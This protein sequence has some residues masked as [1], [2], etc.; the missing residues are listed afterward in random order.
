MEA[1]LKQCD[2][3][4]EMI[5]ASAVKCRYCCEYL[6]HEARR[7]AAGRIPVRLSAYNPGLSAV[8]STIVPGLGQ[9]FQGRILLGI[10]IWL[11]LIGLNLMAVGLFLKAGGYQ[12]ISTLCWLVAALVYVINIYN[13]YH[14]RPLDARTTS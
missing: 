12:W 7:T 2:F 13:A 3:C 14:Y 9:I 1:E 10:I 5:K 6:T 4:A 11:V 8:F